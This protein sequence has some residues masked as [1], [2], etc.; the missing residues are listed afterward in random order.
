MSYYLDAMLLFDCFLV[1]WMLSVCVH[2]LFDLYMVL[3]ASH[4]LVGCVNVLLSH[5][6]WISNAL[7]FV[8]TR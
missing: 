3:F 4:A 2:V 1:C 8:S 7:C 5:F 6:L